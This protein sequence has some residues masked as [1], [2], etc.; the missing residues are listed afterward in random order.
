L[1]PQLCC[2]GAQLAAGSITCG[3]G[4]AA[5]KV[6]EE[7]GNDNLLKTVETVKTPENFAI[8][9]RILVIGHQIKVKFEE[10]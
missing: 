10:I 1:L 6:I 4:C 5:T 9:C 7:N 3:I 8:S 2:S